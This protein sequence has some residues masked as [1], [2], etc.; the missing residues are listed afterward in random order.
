M[1]PSIMD[2]GFEP[3]WDCVDNDLEDLICL[4]KDE[5]SNMHDS[6]EPFV[7][8]IERASAEC[9]RS[10]AVASHKNVRKRSIEQVH[11]K[12]KRHGIIDAAKTL[13]YA[14]PKTSTTSQSLSHLVLCAYQHLCANGSTRESDNEMIETLTR[15]T[16]SFISTTT[17]PDAGVWI[18]QC[19]HAIDYLCW[20]FLIM[21]DDVRTTSLADLSVYQEVELAL[22]GGV[23]LDVT[24]DKLH[25]LIRELR[26]YKIDAFN[27][28]DAFECFVARCCREAVYASCGSAPMECVLSSMYGEGKIPHLTEWLKMECDGSFRDRTH[29]LSHVYHERCYTNMTLING[30]TKSTNMR[31]RCDVEMCTFSEERNPRFVDCFRRMMTVTTKNMSYQSKLIDVLKDVNGDLAELYLEFRERGIIVLLSSL[32]VHVFV[33]RISIWKDVLLYQLV[34]SDREMRMN[35]IAF[36]KLL[37]KQYITFPETIK[38]TAATRRSC[39]RDRW[40]RELANAFTCSDVLTQKMFVFQRPHSVRS[41]ELMSDNYVNARWSLFS[42]WL[43]TKLTRAV[44]TKKDVHSHSTIREDEF[45]PAYLARAC[46]DSRRALSSRVPLIYSNHSICIT[47]KFVQ[48]MDGMD[49]TQWSPGVAIRSKTECVESTLEWLRSCGATNKQ[50]RFLKDAFNDALPTHDHAFEF[51]LRTLTYHY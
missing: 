43:K 27:L 14:H 32:L 40:W 8:Y 6:S 36:P 15:L 30:Y 10:F 49:H 38:H 29:P 45:I 1:E 26:S 17:I 22:F 25:D 12:R 39:E 13:D 44:F 11:G 3:S 4:W 37:K 20:V 7:D 34:P 18:R 24:I 47:S 2:N 33:T 21:Q 50:C 5:H 23:S 41:V 31:D 51:L 46:V 42:E 16:I 9:A 35:D 19:N 28:P 48:L